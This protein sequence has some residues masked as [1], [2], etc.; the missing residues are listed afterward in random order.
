MAAS[1]PT[2]MVTVAA[3]MHMTVAVAMPA[4]NLN[5][6]FVWRGKRRNSQPGGSGCGHCQRGCEQCYTNQNNAFHAVSSHR[7]I[8]ISGSISDA[9]I[10]S[11]RAQKSKIF[12]ERT[13]IAD[14]SRPAD[15]ARRTMRATSSS[16]MRCGIPLLRSWCRVRRPGPSSFG[17]SE[18]VCG[19]SPV[20]QPG[21]ASPGRRL[22]LAVA[23][24]VA[25]LRGGCRQPLPAAERWSAD[26]CRSRSA[27]AIDG[28]IEGG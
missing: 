13:S 4:S 20:Q 9:W 14:T 26:W 27:R 8:A 25:I 19:R 28:R 5:Y 6:G 10:C 17:A 24:Q 7:M 16:G 1:A 21:P 18:Q 22:L 11:A 3:A 15:H 12:A 2:I 23:Q